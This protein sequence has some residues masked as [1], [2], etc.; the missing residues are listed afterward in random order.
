VA[1]AGRLA[2]VG[3]A[4]RGTVQGIPPGRAR[5]CPT[6]AAPSPRHA[7]RPRPIPARA[8]LDRPARV[9]PLTGTR[10]SRGSTWCRSARTPRLASFWRWSWSTRF[11]AC[12]LACSWAPPDHR[13][14]AGARALGTRPARGPTPRARRGVRRAPAATRRSL[15]ALRRHRGAAAPL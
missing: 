7:R 11:D 4:R 13:R 12:A 1:P 14:P 9:R 6:S 15:G 10:S 8:T 2:A 5:R 3:R